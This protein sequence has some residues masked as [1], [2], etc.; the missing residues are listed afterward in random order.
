MKYLIVVLALIAIGVIA[1]FVIKKSI[2]LLLAAIV[3]IIAGY[4]FAV[5]TIA[6][7]E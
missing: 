5:S 1:L 4:F 3:A 2:A 6:K 7:E